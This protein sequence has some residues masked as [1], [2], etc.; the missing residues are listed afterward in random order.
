[1][2]WIDNLWDSV[3][4]FFVAQFNAVW[5]G[6]Q[7]MLSGALSKI[8][9]DPVVGAFQ[10]TDDEWDR[11]T[12]FWIDLGLMDQQ[13]A[14][15]IRTLARLKWPDDTIMYYVT[16]FMLQASYIQEMTYAV[17]TDMRHKVYSQERPTELDPATL[18]ACAF[19]APEKTEDIRQKLAETGYSDEKI[20]YLFLS[21]Y[22]LYQ[23]NTI[24]DLFLKGHI[25]E[26]LLYVR[27]RELG[28]TDTRIEEIIQT[29]D[30]TPPINDLVRFAYRAL[31][32]AETRQKWPWM[33]DA[34]GGFS[35]WAEKQGLS[36]DWAEMYWAAHWQQPGLRET[37]EMLHRGKISAD[38]VIYALEARG[39]SKYWQEKLLSISYQPYTRVDV[40]RMH[41]IGVIDDAGLV[42]AYQ[43]LGYDPD[44][45]EAMAA[46]TV[47]YNQQNDRDLTRSQI[48]NAYKTHLISEQE[49]KTLLEE[50]EYPE[51]ETDFLLAYWEWEKQ[52]NYEDRVIDN[53]GDRYKNNLID[54]YEVREELGKL[55]IEGRRV[56][57]LLKEW[58]VDKF[59]GRKLPSKTDLNKF[60]KNELLNYDELFQEYKKL[61]YSSRYARMYADLA[62]MTIKRGSNGNA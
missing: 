7:D 40:R 60:Y 46:F 52:K 43:D 18:A 24:R 10:A 3:R 53:I 32:S 61:G 62:H 21:Y 42:E 55:A 50:I 31:F 30:V 20:D 54:S 23:E 12:Q 13:T 27:M 51:A 41:D 1:M 17:T 5:S 38:D 19:I 14:E 25:D 56:E 39:F 29:W 15:N 59:V 35:E 34:P 2:G 44:R 33:Y 47:R 37:F 11:M 58:E 45:S 49:T 6:F 9:E 4:A 16:T 48:E 36:S 26:N 8:G 22:K 28:Y 57:I